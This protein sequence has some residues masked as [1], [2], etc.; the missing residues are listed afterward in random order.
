MSNPVTRICVISD[1]HLS[2]IYGFFYRNFQAAAETIAELAPDM[3]IHGGDMCVNGADLEE[4]L[5]FTA[6]AHRRGIGVPTYF[7]PGNHDIGDSP[8]RQDVKQPTNGERCTRYARHFGQG[9]WMVEA[10]DWRLI[11]LDSLNLGSGTPKE[12]Q[13]WAWLEETL[14][15]AGSAPI[16]LCLHKPFYL[17][18]PGEEGVDPGLTIDPQARERLE[19]LLAPANL[20]AVISGHLHQHR[21][22]DIGGVAHIWAPATSFRSSVNHGG[23]PELGLMMLTLEGQAFDMDLIRVPGFESRDLATIKEHGRYQWL[24]DMPPCPPDAPELDELGLR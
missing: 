4:D 5:V 15:R 10:G 19:A 24:R 11:G 16:A 6:L 3:V 14:A 17:N 12:A 7:V 9:M 1:T 8:S 23:D 21:V 13:Q 20:R 22:H 2:P 18:G